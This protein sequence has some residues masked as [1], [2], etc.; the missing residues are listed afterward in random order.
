MGWSGSF[1]EG[2]EFE[3]LLARG[4]TAWEV[5]AGGKLGAD[6]WILS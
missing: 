4:W 5:R 6:I 3:Q 2:E 1:L